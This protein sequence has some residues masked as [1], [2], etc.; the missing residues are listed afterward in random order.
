MFFLCLRK[1]LYLT[2]QRPLTHLTSWKYF[3]LHIYITPNFSTFFSYLVDYSISLLL[4]FS[5]L[6]VWMFNY[7]DSVLPLHSFFYVYFFTVCTL[8]VYNLL[9]LI[10][11]KIYVTRRS[12][13]H[14]LRL[15]TKY[16]YISLA[17]NLSHYLLEVILKLLFRGTR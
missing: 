6:D 13:Y 15:E 2:I 12:G 1:R 7:W 9:L 14:Y 16:E 11:D 10:N 3:L 17:M 5:F 8:W 4:N